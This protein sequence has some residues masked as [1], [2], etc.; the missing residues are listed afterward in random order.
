LQPLPLF[1]RRRLTL[2][3]AGAFTIRVLRRA[4]ASLYRNDANAA[5]FNLDDGA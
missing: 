4:L 2:K 1:I 5:T 3:F